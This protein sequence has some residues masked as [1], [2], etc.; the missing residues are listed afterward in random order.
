[1]LTQIPGSQRSNVADSTAR[2]L[3]RSI[4]HR[5]LLF[6][7]VS[8][9]YGSRL[10]ISFGNES[11]NGSCPSY[12]H[13]CFH[14]DIGMGEGRFDI[15]LNRDRLLYFEAHYGD[16]L[17]NVRHLAVYNSGSTL[18]SREMSDET[19]KHI[20]N[21]AKSLEGC[22]V[23]SFESREMYVT[24]GR[25]DILAEG[26]RADQ[27]PRVVLG[28]ETQ[29]DD[30]RIGLLRKAMQK[31]SIETAFR[32]VSTHGRA[33]IDA[34]L[35][36]QL[37]GVV[38]QAAIDEA[39]RTVCYL[40]RLKERHNIPLDINF[41]PYYPGRMGVS[42]F[43]DHPRAD[44]RDAAAAIVRISGILRRD[45]PDSQLFIGWQDEGYDTEQEKRADELRA[46]MG[47][48]DRFN[49]SQDPGVLSGA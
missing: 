21:Y 31:S 22:R 1:M 20:L 14:C 32:T 17:R 13:Q 12:G 7:P 11:R 15:S 23:V 3:L 35:L 41:H 27:Q 46:W 6:D 49:I 16:A 44:V 34:N 10:A 5:A 4:P 40:L 29:S 45:S 25:L 8:D 28:V 18:N 36:F 47:R 48:F 19:L 33:G 37:P 42:R 2:I 26:L 9:S 38:G 39:V 43:P 30:I 24:P